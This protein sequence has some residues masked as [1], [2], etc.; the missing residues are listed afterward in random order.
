M[1]E[2][3]RT[4]FVRETGDFWV[5]VPAVEQ[6]RVRRA[7][8]ADLADAAEVSDVTASAT[9]AGEASS[10]PP[11]EAPAPAAAEP[12]VTLNENGE[13]VGETTTVSASSSVAFALY[14]VVL[15]TTAFV[16]M[17]WAVAVSL[18][19]FYNFLFPCPH[20]IEPCFSLPPPSVHKNTICACL[21][22]IFIATKCVKRLERGN[23][24]FVFR[25]FSWTLFRKN[26]KNFLRLYSIEAE[27]NWK[28]D[29]D[30]IWFVVLEWQ[31][32]PSVRRNWKNDRIGR[33]FEFRR[34]FQSPQRRLRLRY[35]SCHLTDPASVY[36]FPSLVLFWIFPVLF[37]V[38][39][40]NDRCNM[41][42]IWQIVR[43]SGIDYSKQRFK[44]NTE[45]GNEKPRKKIE[46]GTRE[47]ETCH[48]RWEPTGGNDV[49]FDSTKRRKVQRFSDPHNAS[50]N[51]TKL[52]E[53]KKR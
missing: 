14:S 49:S 5:A 11:T 7:D 25:R 51:Q 44:V 33:L 40:H 38:W 46:W 20:P 47:K 31:P 52:T 42:N 16:F 21:K 50:P 37:L 10:E 29:E 24:S 1:N 22:Y 2:W 30:S 13:P 45:V 36:R 39:L 3:K 15:V 4:T 17:L 32:H 6:V 48:I 53:Q 35:V 28:F 34:R 18:Q 26:S 43:Q 41:Q 23:V 27:W 12:T 9:D 8:I 19:S